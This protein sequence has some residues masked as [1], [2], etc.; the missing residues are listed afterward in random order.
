MAEQPNF[1]SI[2]TADVRY[3]KNLSPSEKIMFAE[4]TA[5]SNKQ[6]YCSASNNYFADLYGVTKTTISRWIRNLIK[7]GY[8]KSVLIKD[9]KEIKG[10]KL[11]PITD[12][13]NKNVDTPINK[14]DNT[15]LQKSGEGINKNVKKPINKNVKENNTSINNTSINNKKIYK[16]GEQEL[17]FERI[18]DYLNRKTNRTGNQKFSPANKQTQKLIKGRFS[19][20]YE[21]EDFKTVIDNKCREWGGTEMATYLTPNTLFKPTTFETYLKQITVK[22]KHNHQNYR[23]ATDWSKKQG[24]PPESPPTMTDEEMN[25][26]FSNSGGQ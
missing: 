3:N 2:L 18:I 1:Y 9:G 5:L 10:R 7:E 26:I 8:I 11:Y 13:H 14:N 22:P 15:S 12:T 23:Q 6:G 19:E 4:I 24:N 20:G 21:A 16:K 17:P 25:A